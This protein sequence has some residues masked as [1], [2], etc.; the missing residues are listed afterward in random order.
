MRLHGG[1]ALVGRC[2]GLVE[3]YGCGHERFLKFADPVLWRRT[4]A[5]SAVSA[6]QRRMRGLFREIEFAKF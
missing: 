4:A 6:E 2:I 3:R 1:V 5:L